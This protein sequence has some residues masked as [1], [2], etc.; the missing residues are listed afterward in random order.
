MKAFPGMDI[1]AQYEG[2]WEDKFLV[3]F[4]GMDLR[5]YFAI[6]IVQAMITNKNIEKRHPDEMSIVQDAYIIADYM[7]EARNGTI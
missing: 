3:P 1:R 2:P 4:T 7:M 6:H 5:D